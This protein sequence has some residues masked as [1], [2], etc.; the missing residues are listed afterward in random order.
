MRR[1]FAVFVVLAFSKFGVTQAAQVQVSGTMGSGGPGFALINSPAVV[2]NADADHTMIYPEMTGSSGVLVITSSVA[3]SGPRNL[4]PPMVKGYIWAVENNTTG[5]QSVTVRGATGTGVTIANGATA[6]VF[7]DGTNY[8]S[9]SGITGITNLIASPGSWPSWLTPSVIN[10]T[11]VPQLSVAASAIPNSALANTTT[12]INSVSCM[13]G[14]SCTVSS[15]APSSP[16]TVT[17]S[18]GAGTGATCSLAAGSSN[19][20]GLVS[21][22]TGTSPTINTVVVTITYNGAPL[23]VRFAGCAITPTI[24]YAAAASPNIIAFNGSNTTNWA[25]QDVNSPLVA[26]TQYQWSYVCSY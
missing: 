18:T 24:S 10:A 26:T 15:F 6:V 16:P 2:F 13:L 23:A 25:I 14:G 4:I 17:C 7:C 1:L 21:V 9:G 12:T 5:G 11:T 20:G 3:L 8:I 19:T 22:L